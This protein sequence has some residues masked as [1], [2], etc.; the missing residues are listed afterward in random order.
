MLWIDSVPSVRFQ[1]TNT[2]ATT[3]PTGPKL[4]RE[5]GHKG[6][7]TDGH[8]P[9]RS[10]AMNQ[11]VRNSRHFAISRTSTGSGVIWR[12]APP[13]SPTLLVLQHIACEPPA[14]YEDELLAWGATLQRVMVDEGEPL[15]DWREFAGIIAMGGPMGAYEDDRLPWLAPEKRL[16]A[17]AVHAGKPLWGVCLGAQL[18]AG[19]LGARVFAGPAPEVGVLSV[20]TTPAAAQDPVFGGTPEEFAALQW[21][22]DT[23][24]LPAGATLLARSDAYEQQAFV[25]RRAYGLQFHIEI[26]SG[27]TAAWGEVPA[28][29]ES[30][31]RTLGTGALTPLVAQVRQ[32][33]GAMTGLA[34]RLFANWLANQVGLPA[35]P[36]VD[37]APLRAPVERPPDG[38]GGTRARIQVP[39]RYPAA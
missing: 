18:L 2:A 32:N 35:P 27:L 9:E 6:D 25:F 29:A 37:A 3:R 5:P 22:G 13:D 23:F 16:I 21:H 15:P 17:E 8:R 12:M 10:D 38:A 33:E 28:Y 20:R 14:A 36:G 26:D 39:R 24:E 31:E 34:H 11:E 30:L 4:P 7:R 19:A 1:S